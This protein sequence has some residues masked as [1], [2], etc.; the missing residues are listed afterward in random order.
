[1][2]IPL[3]QIAYDLRSVFENTSCFA[4]FGWIIRPRDMVW[5]ICFTMFDKSYSL[6]CYYVFE[7]STVSADGHATWGTEPSA[8]LVVSI[9]STYKNIVRLQRLPLFHDLTLK[10]SDSSIFFPIWW[11]WWWWWRWWWW[12]G[13]GG[14]WL[15]RRRRR[16]EE[17]KMF[18]QYMLTKWQ[19][20]THQMFVS[21]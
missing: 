16:K 17:M 5:P 7:I 4:M 6:L 12:G 8:S 15:V 21:C 9:F 20:I 3:H 14:G 18:S 2:E 11:W 1:M 13:G 10:T 19:S